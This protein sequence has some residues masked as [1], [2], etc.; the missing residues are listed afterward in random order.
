ME[1]KAN[2]V[3]I[4]SFVL[5]VFVAVLGFIMWIVK[6]D[7]DKEFAKYDIYFQESVAGLGVGGAVRYQGLDVG[8]VSAIDI[9]PE[10]PNRVRVTIKIDAETPV[11][12]DA[13]ASLQSQGFTGVAYILIEG[14]SQS[15]PPLL[16]K[17]GHEHPVIASRPS[18]LAELFTDVPTLVGEASLTLSQLRELL[19]Q[20]NRDHVTEILRNVNEVTG[21]VAERKEDLQATIVNL[22]QALAE[23]K[24]LA[25]T[26]NSLAASLEGRVNTEMVQTLTDISAT[27]KSVE[28]VAND[29]DEIVNDAKGPVGSFATNTLPEI[30]ALVTETRRLA[31]TLARVAEKLERNPGEFLFPG[32][33][34]EYQAK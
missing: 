15:A 34:P 20:E 22:N 13:V 25:V 17:D 32:G 19:S 8:Q 31:A 12:S 18:A 7:I 26:L 23:Y 3:L 28:N 30:S 29:L 10:Q 33:Q 24:E 1:T 2:Y 4:G 16:A 27:A 14:G 9:D 21:G 5:F 6:L 11:R